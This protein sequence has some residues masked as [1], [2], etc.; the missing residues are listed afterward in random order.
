ML[1]FK[2]TQGIFKWDKATL[3]LTFQLW[4]FQSL[5][6]NCGTCHEKDEVDWRFLPFSLQSFRYWS[7]VSAKQ[8]LF[9]LILVIS[10]KACVLNP[11]VTS[12]SPRIFSLFFLVRQRKANF[13]FKVWH[14]EPA[15]ITSA[16]VTVGC[17]WLSHKSPA[18]NIKRKGGVVNL[19]PFFEFL[20]V[21][22]ET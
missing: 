14:W 3:F 8:F 18:S 22:K 7:Q 5:S 12:Q 11:A 6:E 1:K 16:L 21:M 9:T 13:S 17:G 15:R 10:L 20:S 4:L 19:L 2:C